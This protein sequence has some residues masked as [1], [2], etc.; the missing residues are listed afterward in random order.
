M[1][2]DERGDKASFRAAVVF[3]GVLCERYY[4]AS[5]RRLGIYWRYICHD[6]LT[7]AQHST[8]AYNP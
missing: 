6:C 3:L 8:E 7:A 5:R 2:L 4:I 1:Q